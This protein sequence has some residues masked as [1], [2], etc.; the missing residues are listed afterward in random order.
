MYLGHLVEITDTNTIFKNPIHPYTKALLSAVPEVNPHVKKNQIIL[1]G[2][3]PSPLD[4]PSGC[5]F[6]N[7]CPYAETICREAIPTLHELVPGHSV[8]CFLAR[9]M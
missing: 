7:R 3:I 6:H 5:V 1:K 2:D 8:S 9:K 4:P